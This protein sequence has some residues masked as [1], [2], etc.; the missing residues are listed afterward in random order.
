MAITGTT[1]NPTA[2]GLKTR[3]SLKAGH[4]S[5]MPGKNHNQTIVRGAASGK[6][7][8]VRT[9]VKAGQ[10]TGRTI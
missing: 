9:K 8:K 6:A 2:A 10:G 1:N 7:L 5:P 4:K 3:T